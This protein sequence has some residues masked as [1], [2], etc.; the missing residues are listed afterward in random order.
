MCL[1]AIRVKLSL[2]S[3]EHVISNFVFD[4]RLLEAHYASKLAMCLLAIR[5][6]NIGL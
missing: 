6:K 2:A 4:E 3:C 5:T 1:L